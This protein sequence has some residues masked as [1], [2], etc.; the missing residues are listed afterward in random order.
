VNRALLW[1]LGGLGVLVLA[2]LAIAP[3]LLR[4]LGVFG[5]LVGL[6]LVA[7]LPA[8]LVAVLFVSSRRRRGAPRPVAAPPP[9]TSSSDAP[10][11]PHG[12]GA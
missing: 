12:Q 7:V 3:E 10:D 8:A 4:D 6:A 1:L 9:D 5:S 11:R 2:V